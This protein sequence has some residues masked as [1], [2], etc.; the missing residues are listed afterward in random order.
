MYKDYNRIIIF[1]ERDKI[2]FS[3]GIPYILVLPYRTQQNYVTL[4]HQKT[5]KERKVMPKECIST[6]ATADIH[7]FFLCGSAIKFPSY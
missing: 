1:T 7:T 6:S 5:E 4:Y 3:G 2:A